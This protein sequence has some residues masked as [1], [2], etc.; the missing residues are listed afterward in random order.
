MCFLMKKLVLAVTFW[1]NT[2]EAIMTH[3]CEI[4]FLEI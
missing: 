2:G 3:Y 1:Y 4:H